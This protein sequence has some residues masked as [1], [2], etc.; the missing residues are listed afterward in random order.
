MK[1]FNTLLKAFYVIP[2]MIGATLIFLPGLGWTAKETPVASVN[3]KTITLEFL[4]KKYR[5]SLLYSQGKPPSKAD[6]LNDLVKRELGIQEA[7]KIG[8]N[9]DPEVIDKTNTVLYNALLEKKLAKDFEKIDVSDDE[10][11][12]YYSK[13]PEIRTSHIFI[14]IVP[15]SPKEVETKAH[16]K[17]KKIDAIVKEGKMSFAEVAQKYSEGVEAPLGGDVDYQTRSGLDPAYYDA[18]LALRSPGKVSGV[19]RSSIG[20]HIIRLTAIR[21]W[22]EADVGKVKRLVFEKK[23]EE[24]FEKYMAQLRRAAKV[25]VNSSLIK[26]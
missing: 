1:T 25:T 2:S 9:K 13:N 3:G 11:K 18:A 7:T 19:L 10:A 8:L 24:I 21:P 20:Y 12:N 5:E 23:R 6:V 22:S 26:E 17:I 14:P 4:D 16:E 15:G